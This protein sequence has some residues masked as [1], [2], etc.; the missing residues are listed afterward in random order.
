VGLEWRAA[1]IGTGGGVKGRTY[2]I[3]G[4]QDDFARKRVSI[5]DN[6]LSEWAR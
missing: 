4:F 6:P 5:Q 1:K 3:P 2:N